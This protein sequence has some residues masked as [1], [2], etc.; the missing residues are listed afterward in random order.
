MQFSAVLSSES[1][2]TMTKRGKLWLRAAGIRAAKTVAQA[3]LA[4]IGTA[5]AMSEID[6]KYVISTSLLAGILSIL[7]SIKGLPEVKDKE[8]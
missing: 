1:E 3:A 7:T 4:G 6:W 5:A 8:E 2:V